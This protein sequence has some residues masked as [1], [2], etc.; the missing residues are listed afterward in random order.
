MAREFILGTL[1]LAILLAAILACLLFALRDL[2]LERIAGNVPQ[3]SGAIP[4][5]R[6]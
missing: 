4:L 1:S 2:L 5:S 3:P 6:S